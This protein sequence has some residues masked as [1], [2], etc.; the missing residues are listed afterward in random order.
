MSDFCTV[1]TRFDFKQPIYGL[2]APNG[3]LIECDRRKTISA[4]VQNEG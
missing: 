4:A 1:T 3:S 2:L